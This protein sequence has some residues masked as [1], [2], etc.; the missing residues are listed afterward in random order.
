[1]VLTTF[2]DEESAKRVARE[3]VEKRLVACVNLMPQ[4][5]S[6]YRWEGK[7]CEEGE[8]LAVM[9]TTKEKYPQLEKT[10]GEIHPYEVPEVLAIPAVAGSDGYLDF[11]RRG[12]N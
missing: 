12:V 8:V 3:L 6:V 1:M 5:T 11:V 9:K 2:G 10:L 7:V 4:M